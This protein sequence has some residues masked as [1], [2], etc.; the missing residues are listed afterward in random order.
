MAEKNYRFTKL[1]V[2]K[3]DN[4]NVIPANPSALIVKG[5]INC[6]VKE[7]QKTEVNTTLDSGGQ[8]SKK[9]RGSSDF[10][11]N[12]ECKTT[13]DMMPF[14]VTHV[15]G[16]PAVPVSAETDTWTTLTSYA[17]FNKHTL[18][19][20]IVSLAGTTAFMLVC[21]TGG[22]TG[23][24][25]PV[26]TE[27]GE[28]ITDGTVV[29][30]ARLPI[31]KYTGSSEAC[32][33]SFGMEG[34]ATSGCSLTPD[35]FVKRFQGNYLDGYEFSKSNGTVIHKYSMP[36]KGSSAVDSV[37]GNPD[38]TP[39]TSIDTEAGYTEVLTVDK[40]FRYDDLMI[41]FDGA[42]PIDARDFTMSINRAVV[43]DDALEVGTK[44]Y[45][46]PNMVV[47]GSYMLKFTKAQY[48]A[49]YRSTAQEVKVLYGNDSGSVAHFTLPSVEGDRVD[50][51]FTTDKVAYMTIPLTADGD[52]TTK[53][54]SYIVYSEVKYQ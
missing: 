20:D 42:E 8:G 50:P 39:F 14:I 28:I 33:P 41:Q 37:I 54:I 1:R 46:N 44:V 38:G 19:G 21:K 40:A 30:E 11:G 43:L 35:T 24:T 15:L 17:K 25:E 5:L 16:Q 29:W 32:L 26:P 49:S 6:D 22:D 2:W 12:M 53:T 7:T 36:V 48:E 31:W 4:A 47:E 52:N 3:E 9:D 13:G 23:A 45:D 51:D 10:A 34:E 27:V 18:A